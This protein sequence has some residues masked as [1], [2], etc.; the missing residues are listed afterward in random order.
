MSVF[1]I[2][3]HDA[4]IRIEVYGAS[5]HELFENA[6]KGIFS[7]LTDPAHVRPV[8]EK[9]VV[10]NGNGELLVNFLNELLFIWDV[11]RFIPVEIAVDF[12]PDGVSALLKGENFDE[13]RHFI[14]LEM[15]AVT[16]HN[17]S[18]TE[19]NGTYKATFVIDV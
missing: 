3:D 16:Y 6:A 14:Q 8:T 15:K 1:R 5:R 2:L 9:K 18:M 17:F 11:E 4:D 10:V 13:E 7:L 12:V 19:D